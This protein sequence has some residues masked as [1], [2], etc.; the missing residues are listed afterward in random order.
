MSLAFQA[1]N[2][3]TR[4][5]DAFRRE[6]E[7]VVRET[8]VVKFVGTGIR[9][10]SDF[11]DF[12][13]EILPDRMA[14]DH[15]STPREDVGE[16][17][18]TSTEY[19]P[20]LRIPLHNEMSY[21]GR[22]PMRLVFAC[23]Q[24]ARKGGATPL[25]SSHEVL[26]RLSPSVRTA[27]EERGVRYVRNFNGGVDL[28]WQETF[29]TDDRSGVEDVCRATG[30]RWEWGEGDRLRTWE[31]RPAVLEHP[32]TG[33]PCWFNQAHLFHVSGLPPA[34][35]ASLLEAVGQDALPRNAYFAD[36]SP[37]EDGMLEEVRAAYDEEAVDVAWQ[38][39][40]VVVI[41][42]VRVA[43]GRTPFAGQR[44]VLVAMAEPCS[45]EVAS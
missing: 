12:V 11:R 21:T 27:F 5:S 7:E 44:R 6:F 15:G 35:R 31:D 30:V 8:G 1:I 32:E 28:T 3:P 14:Y 13:D 19:P 42:N 26:N 39:E 22:W 4:G 36:G 29:R 23:L 34:V 43:H 33:L 10:D 37:I 17:V 38:A 20:R 41:D 18:Y 2:T 40:D 9:S 16:R 25:A 24:P 45:G